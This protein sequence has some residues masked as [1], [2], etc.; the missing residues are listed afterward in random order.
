MG[1]REGKG[2]W[3]AD[4]PIQHTQPN[5]YKTN[6]DASRVLVVANA[7]GG[8]GKT[9]VCACLGARFSEILTNP[10]CS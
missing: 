4:T 2:L 1:C 9:S 6:I 7:K 5:E 3:L 8:V 10:F